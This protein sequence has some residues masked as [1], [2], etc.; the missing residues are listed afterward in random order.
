[1]SLVFKKLFLH[2]RYLSSDPFENAAEA[3][4]A[5]CAGWRGKSFWQQVWFWW[6]FSE[7]WKSLISWRMSG[8]NLLFSRDI[9]WKLSMASRN[10]VWKV[11]GVCSKT[12]TSVPAVQGSMKSWRVEGKG[13]EFSGQCCRGEH[14]R[15]V[16]KSSVPT[17]ILTSLVCLRTILVRAVT[18]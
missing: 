15:V 1:M 4:A 16:V 18:S 12:A 9:K 2:F 13:A 11:S 6:S 8:E 14:L 3:F 17:L 10:Q 5:L 7:K